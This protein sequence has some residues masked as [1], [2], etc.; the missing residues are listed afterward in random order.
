MHP[1][2]LIG[3]P[4]VI[5]DLMLPAIRDVLGHLGQEVERVEHLEVARH[6]GE[7]IHI[8]RHGKG[9][10]VRV[11]GTVED[12][13]VVRDRNHAGKT[14]RTAGDVLD[15]TLHATMVTAI[16]PH[17]RIDAKPGVL[18][19]PHTCRHLERDLALVKQQVE[20]MFLPDLRRAILPDVWDVHEESRFGEH[21]LGHDRVDVRVPVDEIAEG[22]HSADHCGHTVVAVDLQ[23]VNIA[24]GHVCGT[25]EL[26]QERAVVPEIDPQPLGYGEHPLSVRDVGK[27]LVFEA[28]GKQQ[29][30]FLVTRGAACALTAGEGNEEL[31]L[32]VWA[33]NTSEPLLEIAALQEL[34]DRG[35]DHG[36]PEAI[37][38]QVSLGVHL[39]E[40]GKMVSDNPEKR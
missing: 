22:L 13:A 29:R 10:A 33:T 5:P 14:E 39:L 12:L 25:A 28:I 31:L 32:A 18:P 21:S 8:A 1:P 26:A 16:D 36:P 11:S 3:V 17:R 40:L 37:N 23:P 24:D 30:P 34:V 6:P 15:Q 35:T 7:Q 27:H 2:R 9:Y 38:L 20:D 4:A 19:P